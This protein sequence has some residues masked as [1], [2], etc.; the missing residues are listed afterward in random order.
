MFLVQGKH[1][2]SFQ[3][4]S[5]FTTVPVDSEKDEALVELIWTSEVVSGTGVA[6]VAVV[7]SA[8]A[9]KVVDCVV[10]ARK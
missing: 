2:G 10:A 7:G 5:L 9:E 1:K 4:T 6:V 3:C 8:D